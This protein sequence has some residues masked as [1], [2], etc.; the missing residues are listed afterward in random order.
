MDRISGLMPQIGWSPL[1]MAATPKTA[2][3]S[4]VEPAKK[5]ANSNGGM[6]ADVD[7]QTPQD[8]AQQ[9]RALGAMAEMRANAARDAGEA[10][11]LPPPDPDPLT[12]PLPTFEVTPLEAKAAALKAAP[13]L[14]E[15]EAPEE[16]HAPEQTDSSALPQSEMAEPAP[17]TKDAPPDDR[18]G[19]PQDGWSQVAERP[20]PSL[21][22]TR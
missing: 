7:T 1:L 20:S 6:G 19:A 5:P 11:N 3:A 12:G 15:A 21:D 13:E 9:A 17:A 14:I 8:H 4:T 16:E 2:P 22:V 10:Q 18:S